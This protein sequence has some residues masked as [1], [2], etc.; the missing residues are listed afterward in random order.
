MEY[1]VKVNKNDLVSAIR[2]ALEIGYKFLP[3]D[4]IISET[5]E[6]ET[7]RFIAIDDLI[8]RRIYKRK[9]QDWFHLA[10]DDWQYQKFST[11]MIHNRYQGDMEIVDQRSWG[12]YIDLQIRR[13]ASED[14][15]ECELT[16][17]LYPRF[18]EPAQKRE[19]RTPEQVK[20]N[21][22]E[23]RSAMDPQLSQKKRRGRKRTA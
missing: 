10:R 17:H 13:T 20:R 6:L 5:S 21:F 1:F 18:W 14:S 9:F 16:L 8:L 15:D 11:T 3:H 2:R 7:I 4:R 12:P 22:S 19:W 23:L